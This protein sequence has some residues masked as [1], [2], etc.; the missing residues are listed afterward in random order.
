[1]GLQ[2]PWLAAEKHGVAQVRDVRLLDV[3]WRDLVPLTRGEVAYETLITTPWLAV[4][5]T[6]WHLASTTHIALAALALARS[7]SSSLAFARFTTPITTH[8]DWAP[9][10]RTSP[11]SR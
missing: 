8:W 2:M 11:C 7:S 10:P 5:L 6:A 9:G 4:S 1:M 3:E